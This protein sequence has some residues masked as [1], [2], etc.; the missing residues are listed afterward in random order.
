MVTT[1]SPLSPLGH[2]LGLV[3]INMQLIGFSLIKLTGS[4][5]LHSG[6]ALGTA[7]GGVDMG[8]GVIMGSGS[9]PASASIMRVSGRSRDSC[10]GLAVTPPWRGPRDHQGPQGWQWEQ[11]SWCWGCPRHTQS[12]HSPSQGSTA[13]R[14]EFL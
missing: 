13:V 2:G 11:Q 4:S 5:V 12:T 6:G 8:K 3:L 14:W 10:S 1:L 9:K 7:Q